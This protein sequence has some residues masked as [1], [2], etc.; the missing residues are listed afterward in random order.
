MR[1]AF[2]A[3]VTALTCLV[4]FFVCF[5]AMVLWPTRRNRL[6]WAVR[7]SRWWS[8]A[9]LWSG[10]VT[11]EVTG[12]EHTATCPA[13]FTFNHSSTLDFVA[14]AALAPEH[15]LVFGKAELSRMPFVGWIWWLSGHPMIRRSARDQWQAVYDGVAARLATGEH[16]T[17]VAPE[18]TR[19]REGGLLPFKKGP[20]HLAIQGRCPIVPWVLENCP[21]RLGPRGLTPGPLRVRILPPIPTD[22]WREETIDAHVEALR[23]VYLRALGLTEAPARP[24]PA[25]PAAPAPVAA[26]I[27]PPVA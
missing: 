4:L 10:G 13:V 24:E 27:R 5:P 19:N 25:A 6:R 3:T 23:D 11:L 1:K 9:I 7:F 2:Q 17:I 20:V 16:T 8:R 18:G 26:R 15:A 22:G 12:R 21:E 14:N